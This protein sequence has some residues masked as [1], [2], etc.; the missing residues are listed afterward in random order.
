MAETEKVN[1]ASEKVLA[2][3]G[4]ERGEFVEKAFEVDDLVDGGRVW[5]GATV[6]RAKRPE[7]E[8]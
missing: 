3:A 8:S 2:K 5:K 7:V 4:W 1:L 6:W